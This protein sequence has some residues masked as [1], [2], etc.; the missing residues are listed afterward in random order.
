MQLYYIGYV[1]NPSANKFVPNI[2]LIIIIFF[3]I[4]VHQDESDEIERAIE[5]ADKHL[6][7]LQQT[8]GSELGDFLDF[9]DDM[10]MDSSDMCNPAAVTTPNGILDTT[11]LFVGA[12]AA[13]GVGNVTVP[14]GVG[15][16]TDVVRG[17]VQT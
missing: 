4:S 9:N 16:S 2:F 8:I 12:T 7:T 3:L 17:L 15:P 11:S 1:P 14:G 5:L 13:N 6:K 10:L